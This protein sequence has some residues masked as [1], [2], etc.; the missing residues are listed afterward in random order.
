MSHA[1]VRSSSIFAAVGLAAAAAAATMGVDPPDLRVNEISGLI[2]TV[3][4]TWSGSNY[5]VRYTVMNGAGVLSSSI[6]LSV[7]AADDLDPRIIINGVGD[8]YVSWWRDAAKDLVIYR[9]K[10][11]ATGVWAPEHTVGLNT[12]S[13]ARPRVALA[14]GKAWVV[15]QVQNARSRSIAAQVIDD[16]PEPIRS[17]VATTSYSGDLDVQA[18]SELNHFWITWIDT[19]SRVGYSEYSADKRLWGMAGYESFASDSVSAARARIR[20]RLLNTNQ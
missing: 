13:N 17:I 12:E 15:F 7:N 5:N 8:A 10:T 16:D 14:F 9:K 4:A 2:E 1:M 19:S 6:F 20:A 3:D 11:Y 18:H